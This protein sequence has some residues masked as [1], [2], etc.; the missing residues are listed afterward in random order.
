LNKLGNSHSNFMSK[1]KE[2]CV[3]G[4][5]ALLGIDAELMLRSA[6]A[7]GPSRA[8]ARNDRRAACSHLT[9]S[10]E[11]LKMKTKL[12]GLMAIAAVFGWSPPANASTYNVSFTIDGVSVTGTIMTDCDSCTLSL[13]TD[14]V[15][16]SF[17]LNGITSIAG[18]PSGVTITGTSVLSASSGDIIFDPTVSGT[19]TFASGSNSL[20]MEAGKL[21]LIDSVIGGGSE[22]ERRSTAAIIA[23]SAVTPLPAALPLFATGLGGLGLLGWRRKRKAQAAA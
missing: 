23:R 22:F 21:T 6:Y 8:C 16:W 19:D 1:K 14:F 5:S 7:P 18:G 15:S 12:L 9:C 3:A 13:N 17:T 10:V 11:D 20:E 2:I 4:H